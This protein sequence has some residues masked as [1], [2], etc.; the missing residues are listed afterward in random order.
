[1]PLQRTLGSM[2]TWKFSSR[3]PLRCTN[4]CHV[5]CRLLSSRSVSLW[6]LMNRGDANKWPIQYVMSQVLAA[7]NHNLQEEYTAIRLPTQGAKDR[8]LAD[9]RFLHEK[10]SALKNIPGASTAML[11]T[12]VSEKTPANAPKRLPADQRIKG[13]LS[14]S[15]SNTQED[16]DPPQP[17]ANSISLSPAP[18]SRPN[19]PALPRPASPQPMLSPQ[20]VRPSTN[21]TSAASRP[22]TPASSPP[23]PPLPSQ[24]TERPPASEPN[25]VNGR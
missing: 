16:M 8:L 18:T 23:L 6:S 5:T 22:A 12:V 24:P 9:A 10:L 25:G 2:T 14:R 15:N 21:G 17:S 7:I 3:R 4:Y 20:I 19:S 13:M 11:V 1:M